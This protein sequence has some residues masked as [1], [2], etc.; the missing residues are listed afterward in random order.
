MKSLEPA[1]N[2]ELAIAQAFRIAPN[3]TNLPVGAVLEE[4]LTNQ[5]HIWSIAGT[6]AGNWNLT[7]RG[8]TTAALSSTITGTA[9]LAAINALPS[10]NGKAT[11]QSGGAIGTAAVLITLGGGDFANS[12]IELPTANVAMTITNNQV[13]SAAGTWLPSPTSA[14]VARALN[15]FA[16]STDGAGNITFADSAVGEEFHQ[17]RL[18]APLYIGGYFRIADLPLAAITGITGGFLNAAKSTELG[19][20]IWG[21]VASGD[22][23]LKVL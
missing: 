10:V 19:R 17:T 5:N 21:S 23:L 13:G 22:G 4:S 14:S 7:F 8:F 18:T 3:L 15:K 9:L 16:L 11:A 1:I 12:P 6:P 20:V 2:P